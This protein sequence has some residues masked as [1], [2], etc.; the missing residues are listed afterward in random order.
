MKFVSYNI[1]YSRGKDGKHDLGRIAQA[2]E[3]ADVIALQEVVRNMPD[4]PDADQPA[5]LSELLPDYYWVYGPPFDIDAGGPGPD[6]RPV[7]RRGQFGNM[8]LSRYPI[9][10][11]RLFLLPSVRNYG[12]LNIQC[13]AL[14]GMID[15]PGGPLRVYSV[16]LDSVSGSQRLAQIDYLMPRIQDVPRNG[17]TWNGVEIFGRPEIP[18]NEDFVV[19]GD[20]NLIPG[21]PEY[22]RIA[23]APDYFYGQLVTA[24]HWADTWTLAGHDLDEGITWY[25]EDTDWKTGSRLDYG[26]VSAELAARVTGA[27]IDDDAPGSDHQP[28]WFDLDL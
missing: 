10:S 15:L 27:R 21:S 18:L 24:R 14:E 5:R 11:S 3:G 20:C 26:F 23:G 6:G 4:V 7:N 9:L 22:R 16:H 1:Q 12:R 17:G 25:D 19:M 8:L 28:Y 2:V 13:G